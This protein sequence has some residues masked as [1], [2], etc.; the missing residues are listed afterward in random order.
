MTMH[1]VIFVQWCDDGQMMAR[2]KARGWTEDAPES[3]HDLVDEDECNETR[4][5]PS[6]AKAKAWASRNKARD[7]WRQPSIRIYQWPSTRRL[8]WERETV[9]HLRYVG[10]GLGWKE[11]I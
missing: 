1:T 10:D 4:E 8:S 11:L 9:R 5:F 7:F 2:A 6:V 3:V